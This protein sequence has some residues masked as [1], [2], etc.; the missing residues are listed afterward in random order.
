M[1]RITKDVMRKVFNTSMRDGLTHWCSSIDGNF[2]D[3]MNGKPISL[4]CT[5]DNEEYELTKDKLKNGIMQYQEQT[6]DF[7]LNL[8]GMS[9][10]DIIQL[11][12]FGEL[13]Y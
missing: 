9:A 11:A 12:I 1:I 8:D 10:D 3:M 2:D 13:L 4:V 5:D 6:G 7:D